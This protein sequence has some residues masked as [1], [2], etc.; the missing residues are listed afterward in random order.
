[1]SLRAIAP[2]QLAVA[3]INKPT[4]VMVGRWPRAAAGLGRQSIEFALKDYWAKVEPS[5]AEASTRAQ[6]LSLAVYHEDE[7]LA[8][9]VASAWS[10]LSRACHYHPYELPPTEPELRALLGVA[11]RFAATVPQGGER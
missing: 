5:L 8:E 2:L 9:S 4:G 10:A 6:L 11:H 7:K 1:M 3:T